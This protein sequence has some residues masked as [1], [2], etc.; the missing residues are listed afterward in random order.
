M[1]YSLISW[2]LLFP[3]LVALSFMPVAQA[4]VATRAS[5]VYSS[6]WLSLDVDRNYMLWACNDIYN[7]F[8]AN[9]QLLSIIMAMWRT[10]MRKPTGA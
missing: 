7:F 5:I 9:T 3:L 1:K 6:Q 2:L 10:V 4:S 8:L